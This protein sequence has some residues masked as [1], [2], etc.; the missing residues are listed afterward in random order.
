MKFLRNLLASVMG[1]LIALGII[2]MF[3]L[4]IASLAGSSEDVVRVK[5]NSVLEISF[6]EPIKDYGGQFKFTDLQWEYEN[7]NGL[8]NILSAI[9]HARTDDRIRGISINNSFLT[10]GSASAKAIRDAIA[11]FKE[12]GKWVY[13]YG[14]LMV[15]K[16]YYLASVADSVFL[17]PAGEL[18]FRGLSSEVL[19]YKELQEKSGV[20]MEVIRHGKYKS[21][22]EPFLSNEMSEENREQ[23]SELLESLWDTF[24]ADISADRNIPKERLNRL[25]DSL[26]ARTPGLALENGFV[27]ALFYTDE[28]RDL[29]T[30][31]LDEPTSEDINLIT[32]RD[33]AKHVA[34]TRGAYGSNRV[35]VI[36][37]QGEIGY[38]EGSD[39]YIGQ[40][41]MFKALRKA[42]ED[43]KIKAVVLRIDSP[44]GL[45]LTSDLIWR[46]ILVTRKVK[47]VVISMGDMAASG[48]YFMAVAGDYIFAEPST[49]TGSIGVFA[50]IPNMH[51]LADRIG[52]NA[53]QV[54]TNR[55]ST[56]YSLFEPA[57]EEFRELA[58]EQIEDYYREFLNKVAEGR[59]MSVEAVDEVA[60]GRV[61]TGVQALE[62]GLVDELGGLDDAVKYAAEQAG[63]SDY[64][65][66]DY[67]V[68]ETSIEEILRGRSGV[69]LF[70]SKQE[71][72]KQEIGEE[73]FGILQ[74][75]K[76]W[77]EQKGV[78][79][80]LPFE[81]NIR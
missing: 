7:Y 48:G 17:N 15:Q 53:E 51:E 65:T 69:G 14:D 71:L 75:I 38:G 66:I 67:P 62:K 52:I 78:Y 34:Q 3:F 74:N 20:K 80:R 37:A 24:L 77:G 36:Y 28:Y 6:Q 8:N 76:T 21:A 50:T 23:I 64:K 79:A 11:T 57:D 13:A 49:V 30:R 2:F 10:A 47:P 39:D 60:Q 55:H 68:Y 44:G 33:Y 81:I 56:P 5:N 45:A 12:S 4:I 63:I 46:E 58:R 59:N 9:D 1:T 35:A 18:D 22:V 54:N 43:D 27:D 40:G 26:G 41:V 29:I 31:K 70:R 42:R 73:L 19:F 32:I 25:A 61:W 16:D 72:L